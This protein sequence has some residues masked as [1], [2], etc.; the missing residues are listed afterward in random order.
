MLSCKG[1]LW[2]EAAVLYMFN[3]CCLDSLF[4]DPNNKSNADPAIKIPPTINNI[5][6]LEIPL[7]VEEVVDPALEYVDDADPDT[8]GFSMLFKFACA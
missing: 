1:H 7:E 8:V 4:E 3:L 2:Y 5:V 6:V